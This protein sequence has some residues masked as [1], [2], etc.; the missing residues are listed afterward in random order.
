MVGIGLNWW[1]A[2]VVIFASQ[3]ISSIAMAF[4][5][6]AATMYHIGYPTV[7]RAVFGMYGSYYFVAA[8]AA[9]AII[10][11]GVQR[12]H[13]SHLCMPLLT[14]TSIHWCILPFQHDASDLWESLCEYPE[15]YP[16]IYGHHHQ[17][18]AML[19]PFLAHSFHFLF[20]PTLPAEKVLL[21][22]RLRHGSRYCGCLHL[23]HDRVRR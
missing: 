22:Q 12:K 4:N 14:P 17:G 18:H 1:Q 15:P 8:R 2:I 3:M 16:R 6:R 9:L 7:A 21:V 5:S 10:W 19:L 13:S 11:F 20:L 23:L